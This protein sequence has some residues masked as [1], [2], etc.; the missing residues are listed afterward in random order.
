M[1]YS[2][3]GK[4][5]EALKESEAT[6]HEQLNEKIGRLTLSI[7]NQESR[8][9]KI[10][11]MMAV[12]RPKMMFSEGLK[13]QQQQEQQ[14][15]DCLRTTVAEQQKQCHK[16]KNVLE[17][18]MKIFET[19]RRAI[20]LRGKTKAQ[21]QTLGERAE[22]Q[23]AVSSPSPGSSR[24]TVSGMMLP[25]PQSQGFPRNDSGPM[26]S[27]TCPYDKSPLHRELNGE[28]G[29]STDTM[30]CDMPVTYQNNMEQSSQQSLQRQL[31]HLQHQQ[32]VLNAQG[33]ALAAQGGMSGAQ[34]QVFQSLMQQHKAMMPFG[35]SS[36]SSES[37]LRTASDSGKE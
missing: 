35:S 17:G 2:V 18:K 5:I 10:N 27:P 34:L 12:I 14:I 7:K 22:S 9:E 3:K 26:L 37:Q 20:E 16:L 29:T 25:S 31:Q 6:L 4:S 11:K 24:D 33:M 8:L 21:K 28:S 19:K 23:S 36:S 15:Y 32:D 30:R 13:K 1:F